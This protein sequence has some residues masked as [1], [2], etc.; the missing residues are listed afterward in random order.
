MNSDE[1]VTMREIPFAQP[2]RRPNLGRGR[3]VSG[4]NSEM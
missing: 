4:K 2:V 1:A 3:S